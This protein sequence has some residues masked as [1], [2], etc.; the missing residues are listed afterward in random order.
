MEVNFEYVDPFDE[1]YDYLMRV[2]H[3]GRYFFAS[4]ILKNRKSIL[5][6][7][8]ADGYGSYILCKNVEK[9]YGIDCNNSYLKIANEKY[10]FENII[11][12][13]MNFDNETID[14]KYDGIVCFETLEHLKYPERFLKNLYNILDNNGTLI[15]SVPNS[16]YEQ[17]ENGKNKDSY[18][19]H[20]FTYNDIV[21]LI[22][23]IGFNIKNIYGQSYIN[24]IVNKEILEYE[25]T[26]VENDAKTI[27]YP[28][29]IDLDKS[30][31]YIF[32]L[33]KGVDPNE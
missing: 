17:F 30:Y 26:N 20:V 2:E 14:G 27:G 8:C 7:A 18:H 10:S 5:D 21:E 25:I 24:K 13:Q 11:Y 3:L 1:K 19:L 33:G 31:S 9:V 15:V 23:K 29:K 16:I 22:K 32:I 12:K 4:N 6:V 28:N